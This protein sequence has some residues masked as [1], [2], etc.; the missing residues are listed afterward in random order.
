MHNPFDVAITKVYGPY[1]VRPGGS[2]PRR[3]VVIHLANGR[4]TSMSYARWQMTQ[5]LGRTLAPDEHVDHVN[6][7]PMDDRIDNYQL[8]TPAENNRKT[9]LGKA[10][11]FRGIDKGFAHGTMYAWQK[12]RCCCDICSRAKREWNDKRNASRRRK[13]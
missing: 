9:N 7:D 5:H 4:R 1:V 6:D 3:Q 2:R 13:A 11:P 8:L 12:R 10:S